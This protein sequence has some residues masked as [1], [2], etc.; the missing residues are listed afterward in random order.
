MF[1]GT[2]HCVGMT[3][4]QA[5]VLQQSVE[6][7]LDSRAGRTLD[8]GVPDHFATLVHAAGSV[9]TGI[10]DEVLRVG[11]AMSWLGPRGAGA[12]LAAM[13]TAVRDLLAQVEPRQDLRLTRVMEVVIA[14][15]CGKWRQVQTDA[16]GW[17]QRWQGA[18]RGLVRAMEP[19]LGQANR[20]LAAHVVG[21]PS[22]RQGGLGGTPQESTA[23]WSD[24]W[25][26]AVRF[27]CPEQPLLLSEHEAALMLE[28][29]GEGL[30]L[31]T[32]TQT[33]Q[34]FIPP[35]AKAL[36]T[37]HDRPAVFALSSG[38]LFSFP[39]QTTV[40]LLVRDDDVLIKAVTDD[41]EQQARL[42][43]G[44]VVSLT[45]PTTL[46]LRA[47]TCGTTHCPERHRLAGWNPARRVLKGDPDERQEKTEAPLTLWDAVASAVKG[48]QAAL[49]TGAFV[50]GMYFPLL[51]QE[52]FLV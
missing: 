8:I 6:A 2:G 44:E 40:L 47:C 37:V 21:F 33:Y 13:R 30:E 14:Y 25:L 1:Q 11:V 5:A 27:A 7:Y 32:V 43:P 23:L 49:K 28:Y 36:W 38:Q 24:A 48:P 15:G 16:D 17:E 50:Q 9:V 31:T 41:Q 26:L 18:M 29:T 52:D 46:R 39:E 10:T 34:S 51:A 42:K 20:W 35:G 22:D 12:P 4:D 3:D 45:G 19:A